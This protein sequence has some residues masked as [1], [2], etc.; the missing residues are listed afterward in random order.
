LVTVEVSIRI[1]NQ[2]KLVQIIVVS[3][4]GEL[5]PSPIRIVMN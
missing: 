2:I 3:N 5:I 1:L 4:R